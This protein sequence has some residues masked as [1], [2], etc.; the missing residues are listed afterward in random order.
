MKDEKKSKGQQIAELGEIKFRTGDLE[1]STPEH[2]R[3]EEALR[4]SQECLSEVEK[5]ARIGHWKLDLTTGKVTWSDSLYAI[6]QIDPNTDMDLTEVMNELIHPDDRP[7]ATKAI[8]TALS[9]GHLLPFEFRAITPEGRERHIWCSGKVIA[10]ELVGINQNVTERKQIERVL[11]DSEVEYRTLVHNIPGM[12]YRGNQDWSAKFVSGSEVISGYASTLLQS[13]E[14]SWLSIIHPDDR[15]RVETEAIELEERRSSLLQT[16]RII[17]HDGDVRWV[18]DRKT[19]LFSEDGNFMGIAGVV[20]DITDQLRAED[21]IRAQHDLATALSAMSDLNEGLGLCLEAALKV[22]GMD[23]GGVYLF[24]DP[25]GS[26]DLVL[27]KGLPPDLLRSVTHYDPDSENVKL[28]MAGRAVYTR[29]QDLGVLLDNAE[30]GEGM[31]AIA[32]VP[33]HHEQEVIGCLNVASHTIEEVPPSSR[34]A[35]ESIASQIGSAIACLKT[36]EALRNSEEKFSK[37]FQSN[38]ALI[39]LST[40]E[41]GRF[42]EVNDTFLNTLGYTREEITG[43]D[44]KELGLWTDQTQGEKITEAIEEEGLCRDLEMIVRT[45]DGKV[46]HV[47]FSAHPIEIHGEV[48]LMTVMN[49]ITKH[50]QAEEALHRKQDLEQQ[51]LDIAGT[52]FVA[53]DRNQNVIMINKKGCDVLE[54]EEKEIIGKNWFDHFLPERLRDS[55]KTAFD[56]LIAGDYEPVEYFENPVLT[57]SGEEIIVAWHNTVIRDEDGN[58]TS[59]LASG[60]DITERKQAEE[61]KKKLEFR[62][63][64]AQKME[65]IGNL[66]GG[67]AHDLNNILSSVLGFS[68]VAKIDLARG[69][70]LEE[71][72]DEVINAGLRARELVKHILTFSRQAD[73]QRS[74]M[75]IGPIIEETLKFLRATLPTTIEVRADL[76]ISESTVVA[77]P[78]QIHQIIL[79]LCTN[80]SHAMKENGGVIDVRMKEII[81]EDDS[82][83]EFKEMERGKYYRLTVSD[84]GHGILKEFVE[85]IFDPFFTTKEREEGTGLGLSVIHGIVEDMGGVISVYSEPGKGTTFHVL[86]PKHEGETA[87]VASPAYSLEE[88][89]GKILLVDDER[90]ILESSRR[91]LENLGYEVATTTS[92]LEALGIFKSSPDA[93]D[94]I[95][96]DM[97]MPQMT[98]LELSERLMEI[99]PNVPIVLCTGFS[100]GVTK[101]SARGHGFRDMVMKPMIASELVEAVSEALKTAIE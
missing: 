28:V 93:F 30:Y 73:I 69:K 40:L 79:N 97:T 43:K 61:D 33:L 15:E 14:R 59:T 12:V 10:N 58:V 84:T 20:F 49:D 54:Y 5:L 37:A 50:K 9:T 72:L 89:K 23:V 80:A 82:Q 22:S 86:F 39:A 47:L 53:I 7:E 45:K 38:A 74:A 90:G 34:V 6:M 70:N 85:R 17:T 8:E 32:V 100:A 52:I 60:E 2:C 77:D 98:G 94:L 88:G 41:H 21:Q 63:L 51:Y 75:E 35:L 87:D 26:L 18:E 4:E 25:S 68:E 29:H 19:S 71:D 27:H 101:E 16:Y 3:L 66:A 76:S 92:S 48:C 55:V 42:I 46:R 31:R 78:T 65:V 44:S 24:D 95:L 64:Q 99:R 81:L 62:L 1:A 11:R 57:R 96:T 91:I 67:I 56:E 13:G 83:P 36:E